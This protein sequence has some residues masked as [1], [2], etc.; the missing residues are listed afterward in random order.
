MQRQFFATADDLLPVFERVES[1]YELAY[2]LTG[3]LKS[4][5]L[6]TVYSGAAIP[7]LR[8]PAPHP[9]AI[10]C[11][12]YLVTSTHTTVQIQPAPQ[13]AGG[14]RYAVD[15]LANPDSVTIQHGGIF[16]ADVL[17]CGRIA[18]A[19]STPFA[20]QLHRAFAA[21]ISKHFSRIQGYYVGSHAA[22]L[23][24]QGWRLTIGADSPPEFN[25]AA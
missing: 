3:L 19:S 13:N 22:I 8:S 5:Q 12:Q 1:Y 18:T 21:A 14:T 20:L 24:R 9:N 16:G 25:L 11:P 10:C 17:L 15:Q 2:T 23:L 6:S 7:T 4:P